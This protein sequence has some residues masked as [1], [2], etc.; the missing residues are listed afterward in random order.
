MPA[1][2][3]TFYNKGFTLIELLVVIAIIGILSTLAIVA[4]GNARTKARDAKRVADIKQISTALELYYADYGY[5]P[6]I[7]TPGNP[8]TSADGTRTYMAIIPNNPNPRNDGSCLNNNYVY[9]TQNS[10]TSYTINFCLGTSLSHIQS[11]NNNMTPA[12]IVTAGAPPPS[13]VCGDGILDDGE[14]CDDGDLNNDDYCISTCVLASCGDSY[15]W[16]NLGGY[17]ES[18]DDGNDSESPCTSGCA[19]DACGDGIIQDGEECDDGNAVNDDAC[20][21]R[22]FNPRCGDGILHGGE[23]C[24]DGNDLDTDSCNNSCLN[25]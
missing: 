22:C 15:I 12:G 2:R 18:C 25:N 4:L 11:G 9:T 8:L 19:T 14:V 5:Y 23:E 3:N 21:N 17:V 24:D 6:T 7:I 16:S 20:S 13:A 10:D 1:T